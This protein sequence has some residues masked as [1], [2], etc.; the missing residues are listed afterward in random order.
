MLLALDEA[1]RATMHQTLEVLGYRVKVAAGV[2]GLLE[3]LR[4]EDT[5]MILV[6]GIGRSDADV[7]IRARAVRSDLRI[8]LTAEAGHH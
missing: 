5:H 8:L 1:L 6:D 3:A 7:L 2:E 4:A